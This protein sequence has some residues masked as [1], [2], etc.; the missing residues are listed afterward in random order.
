MKAAIIK[1]K[2]IKVPDIYKVT[3]K[4]QSLLPDNFNNYIFNFAENKN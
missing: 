2:L 3:M 4:F 1:S